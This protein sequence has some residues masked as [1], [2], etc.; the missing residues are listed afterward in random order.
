[1]QNYYFLMIEKNIFIENY[2]LQKFYGIREENFNLIVKFF[3]KLKLN[4]RG[5]IIKI[6]GD[7][8]EI[9]IFEK[10]LNNILKHLDIYNNISPTEIKLILNSDD[11]DFINIENKEDVI[12]FNSFGKPIKSRTKNQ[13]KMI[14]EFYKN[15]LIFA[16]GPA[17][18]GKTYIAI[19]LGVKLLKEM[20][21]QKIILS[22]PAVEAGENLGFL[23]GD[24]REKLDPYL[25]PLYDALLDMIPYKKLEKYIEEKIIQIA[26]LAFMRGRTLNNAFVILDEAQNATY[27]QLKMFLTRM[28]ENSKFIV[29]GDLS[30]IDLSHKNDS[31]LIHAKKIL[32][33]I[34][35]ISFI[36]FDKNDIVRH[37]VV[38]QIVDAY[39]KMEKQNSN[40]K[41]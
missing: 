12:L 31:G 35:E 34:K 27:T 36:E 28:G 30:Q 29:T 26:P 4:A 6:I 15:D 14:D 2:D 7:K 32:N 38:T 11:D 19:A 5:E 9:S 10:K 33:N 3:P 8:D 20:K 13:K 21:V 23:P 22:R 39:E 25:Q 41:F 1:M 24:L 16:L 40:D 18:T 37:H 17:G